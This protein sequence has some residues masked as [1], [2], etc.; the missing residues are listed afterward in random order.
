MK[1][2]RSCH[3]L[4]RRPVPVTRNKTFLRI[5]STDSCGIPTEPTWSVKDLLSSYPSPRLSNKTVQKLY[6]LS[7]L[8]PPEEGTPDY[9]NVK[10]DLEEMIRLVEAVRLVDTKE[11]TL[12]GRKV[13]EDADR[14]YTVSTRDNDGQALLQLASQTQ[15]GFYVVDTERRR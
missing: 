9:E 6:E 3:Y 14:E 15:N 8:I 10:H 12:R 11:V 2:I 1:V 5:Y 7:A 13:E 4:L